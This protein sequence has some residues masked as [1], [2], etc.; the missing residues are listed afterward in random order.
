MS[1]EMRYNNKDYQVQQVNFSSAA[2]TTD[3]VDPGAGNLAVLVGLYANNATAGTYKIIEET[4][5]DLSATTPVAD[6]EVV[7][8]G[9][10]PDGGNYKKL[11]ATAVAAK[12]LQITTAT[13]TMIGTVWYIVVP[14]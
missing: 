2:T 10:P 9:S 7:S 11:W 14:A 6:K 4:T 12:K 8:I 1:Q 13:G 5:G 3:L